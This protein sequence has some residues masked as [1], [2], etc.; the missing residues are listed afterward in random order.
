MP[1]YLLGWHASGLPVDRR[2]WRSAGTPGRPASGHP[3]AGSVRR[4]AVIDALAPARLL[5]TAD[6]ER[7]LA[8]AYLSIGVVLVYLVLFDQGSVSDV[9][10]GPLL[11]HHNV[12]HELFHDG[13]HL[14][15]APCH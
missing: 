1:T 8:V 7:A 5:G 13:R 6:A 2:P 4:S 15:N 11:G 12:L 14:A 3:G 10:L 9:V